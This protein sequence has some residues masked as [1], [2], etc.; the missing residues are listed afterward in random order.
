V[1]G[2]RAVLPPGRPADARSFSSIGTGTVSV[3][4]TEEEILGAIQTSRAD[5]GEG[6]ANRNR[7][8]GRSERF[9]GIKEQ[10]DQRPG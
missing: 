8:P 2:K 10:I 5:G 6:Q 3:V 9:S 1:G 7:V 4:V